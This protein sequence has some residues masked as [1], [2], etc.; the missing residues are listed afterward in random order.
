M[1]K[2]VEKR[3]YMCYGCKYLNKKR[4]SVLDSFYAYGCDSNRINLKY[5]KRTGY[6]Q[7]DTQLKQMGCSDG[8]KDVIVLQFGDCIETINKVKQKHKYI[9][10]GLY[11]NNRL[12]YDIENEMFLEVE[13]EWIKQRKVKL[14]NKIK[15]NK[16]CMRLKQSYERTRG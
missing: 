8:R 12:L 1:A 4:K 3:N 7:K 14:I 2:T 11:K 5:Y 10:L 9:Y 15:S 13:T 6:M 16:K